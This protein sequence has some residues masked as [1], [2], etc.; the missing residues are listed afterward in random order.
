MKKGRAILMF[1]RSV[2][3]AWRAADSEEKVTS[4]AGLVTDGG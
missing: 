3:F 2:V 1:N 4:G